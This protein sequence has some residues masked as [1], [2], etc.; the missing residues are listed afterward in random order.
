MSMVI[1]NTVERAVHTIIDIVHVG[2]LIMSIA[3]HSPLCN[4]VD[5]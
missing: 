5:C 2:W 1:H 4:D 3:S